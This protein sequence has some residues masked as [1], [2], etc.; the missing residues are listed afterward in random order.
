MPAKVALPDVRYLDSGSVTVEEFDT[1][2]EALQ[3][4]QEILDA[5]EDGMIPV[6][7]ETEPVDYLDDEEVDID[8]T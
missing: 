2:E 7:F 8:V 3:W 1:V 6:V 5:D 4:A